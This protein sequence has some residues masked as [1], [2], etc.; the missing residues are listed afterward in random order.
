[1]TGRH[2]VRWS[3]GT[4]GKAWSASDDQRRTAPTAQVTRREPIGSAK[5]S[6]DCC[7][8]IAMSENG[9]DRPCSRPASVRCWWGK[10]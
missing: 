5:H 2:D 3:N 4:G 9:M 1:M 8:A 10:I 7:I 6:G